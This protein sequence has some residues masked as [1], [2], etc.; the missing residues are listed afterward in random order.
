[1]KSCQIVFIFV[2]I[3]ASREDFG[4]KLRECIAAIQPKEEPKQVGEVCAETDEPQPLWT[5]FLP[6]S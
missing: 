6:N 3:E 2:P 4:E 1:M 5:W